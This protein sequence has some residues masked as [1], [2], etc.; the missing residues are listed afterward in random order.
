MKARIVGALLTLIASAFAAAHAAGIE[1]PDKVVYHLSS[2][3]EQASDGL[4]NIRKDR[5]SV[6]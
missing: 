4:R 2:G 5:K 6:V 1:G 3:L